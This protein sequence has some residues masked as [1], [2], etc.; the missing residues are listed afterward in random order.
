[1]I[2]AVGAASDRGGGP[3]RLTRRQ[4]LAALG[5]V[6]GA[7]AAYA[8]LRALDLLSEEGSAP[9][10]PPRAS[11]FSLQGRANGTSVVVLGAGLAGLCCAYELEKAGYDVTVLEARTRVG[12]RSLTV[13]P[14]TVV[15]DT[16]GGRQESRL[17][18]GRWF[19]AGPARIAQHHTTMQYCRELGVPLEVFVNENADSFLEVRGEVRRRRSA[20]AD[21]DGY[22]SELLVKALGAGALDAELSQQERVALFDHLRATGALGS[23]RRGY[24]EAPTTE[25]GV[26]GPPDPLL[27]VLGLGLGS[28]LAFDRG[29]HQAM[30]MFHPVGGMDRLVEALA[31]ALHTQV[32]TGEEVLA[33][34]GGGGG[35]EV[36]HRGADGEPRRLRADLGI[37]TLPPRLAAALD[38]TWTAETLAALREPV[39]FVTGKIGLE[40]GRRF[41]EEDERIFGGRSTTSA[42][43]RELW[44]PSTD[45]LGSGGVVIGA[46]PFGPAAERFSRLPHAEREEV[47]LRAGEVLHGP[48]YRSELR[49]SLSVDWATQPHSEGAWC[50]WGLF[51]LAYDRL[52]AGEGGWRFA[53]DWLSRS[54]GWQ[55]GA[56]ES[57]RRCVTGLHQEVL[58]TG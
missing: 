48:A 1:M 3:R 38:T 32:R 8:G 9:F 26:V 39:P 4:A 28:A 36:D 37:C 33:V 14:G 35:V 5:T 41:W 27:D 19:N 45:Y 49:S 55:H 13:R 58:A 47:A 22:V 43:P 54:S 25:A 2:P 44:Y 17:A 12:G 29:W 52:L 11:D 21:A 53:G 30:P 56:L 23:S 40:Y 31:S 6:G 46:Y 50:D 15:S 57:A 34:R 10:E 51:G 20:S 24:R 42:E 7:G 18:E 16:R